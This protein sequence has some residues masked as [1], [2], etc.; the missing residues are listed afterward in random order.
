LVVIAVVLFVAGGAI[1]FGSVISGSKNKSSNTTVISATTT[2]VV[3]ATAKIAAG[4]TGS[5]MVSQGLV[6]IQTISA[7]N[8]VAA[9]LTSLASLN[10]VVLATSVAKGTAIQTTDVTASTS[11]I[12]LPTGMDGITITVSGVDGLAG[13]L[14]Q[15]DRVDVYAN[16]TKV[17]QPQSG[18]WLPSGITLP[19]SELTMTN[20]EVLDVSST[21]PAYAAKDGTTG[22]TIPGSQTLLLAVTPAQSQAINFFTQNETLSVVETQKDTLPPTIGVCKGTGQYTIAP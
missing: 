21:S 1:A 14:Q 22:R 16:L 13:Y 11:T 10:G 17:S 15:G 4:T 9:D 19:C 8:Y 5:E 20:I 2:P 18:G 12:S 3:V 7:K 6:Q